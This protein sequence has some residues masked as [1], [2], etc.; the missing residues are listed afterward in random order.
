MGVKYNRGSLAHGSVLNSEATISHLDFGDG[1]V[2]FITD[3]LELMVIWISTL[4][5]I[6]LHVM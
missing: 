2:S 4:S 6:S 1:Y 5:K 3:D